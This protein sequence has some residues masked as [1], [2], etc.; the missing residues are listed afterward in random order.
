MSTARYHVSQKAWQVTARAGQCPYVAQVGP[1]LF[2]YGAVETAIALAK[3]KG[4]WCQLLKTKRLEALK[5]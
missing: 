1:V 5:T 3:T 4:T 2:T